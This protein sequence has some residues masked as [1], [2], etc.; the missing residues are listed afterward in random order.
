MFVTAVNSSTEIAATIDEPSI[1][2][3]NWLAS[4]GY[5]VAHGREQHDVPEDRSGDEAERLA[6]LDLAMRH[7]LDARAH[8]LAWHSPRIDAHAEQRRLDRVERMPIAG[9]EK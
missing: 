3:M 5:T 8:D 1:S 7:G 9:S 2:S 6:R 4:A